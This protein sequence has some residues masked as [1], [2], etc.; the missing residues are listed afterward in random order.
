MPVPDGAIAAPA[1][2]TPPCR[3]FSKEGPIRP[4]N[5]LLGFRL[6]STF[7]VNHRFPRSRPSLQPNSAQMKNPC[8]LLQPLT[9]S[10]AALLLAPHAIADSI[11]ANNT[12]SLDQVGSWAS[13]GVPG[14][15]DFA[16]WDATVTGTNNTR[17]GS[18]QSWFGIRVLDPGGQVGIG[19]V[20][21]APFEFHAL[22]LG[23]AVWTWRTPPGLSGFNP[24]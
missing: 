21:A 12:T 1:A 15:T 11:K 7:P 22:T 6:P 14:P 9:C 17:L 20:T 2:E 19:N 3:P 13:G 5:S 10:I 23:L 8:R 18:N 24:A 16:I 4:A